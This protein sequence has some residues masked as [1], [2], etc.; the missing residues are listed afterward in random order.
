[1]TAG[2]STSPASDVNRMAWIDIARG[3]GIILVVYGHAMRGN[4]LTADPEGLFSLQDRWIYAFHMPLFFVLS[5]IFLWRSIGKNRA[6]FVKARW[7]QVIYP[8]LLW[9][10][11]T[12]A[13]ELAA[14]H[15]VNSPL[16]WRD[17]ML[18]P[19]IPIEQYWFLYALLIAQLLAV[20]VYPRKWAIV[21]CA[22]AGLAISPYLG[23]AAILFTAFTFLPF[24][25]TG[26]LAGP[27][28]T[29]PA[30]ARPLAAGFCALAGWAALALIGPPAD[31]GLQ[32]L[33]PGLAGSAGVIGLAFLLT[34]TGSM[35]RPLI[36]LGQ[37]SMPIYV[38]H[39]IFTAGT[40]IALKLAGIPAQ[41]TVSLALCVAV[42]LIAPFVAWRLTLA[43]GWGRLLGF[44]DSATPPRP[45][46]RPIASQTA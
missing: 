13:I 45:S 16:T 3:I 35:V 9:S 11:I 4:G 5:G 38:S 17:V 32:Q 21:A 40:R 44:G 25:V 33:L 37:A 8:Y 30:L 18:I 22:V 2:A 19:V 12:A 31:V 20:L 7:W 41:S 23:D 14:S 34:R 15:Y 1:M 27:V 10:G 46:A 6:G 43:T 42:G 26:V 36:L 28:L 24:L 29:G 39:S